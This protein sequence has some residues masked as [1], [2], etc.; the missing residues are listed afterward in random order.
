M[1]RGATFEEIVEAL[2]IERRSVRR[3]ASREAWKYTY[4]ATDSGHA[5]LFTLSFLPED[6][7]LAV[8]RIRAAK[9]LTIP[10]PAALAGHAIGS[11]L[12]GNK[13]EQAEKE[14]IKREAQLAAFNQLTQ[15]KQAIAYARR[16]VLKAGEAYLVASG[17][18]NKKRGIQ[19]FCQ[20]YNSGSIRIADHIHS[21]VDKVSLS[22]FNRW[23]A[24]LTDKGVIGLAPGYYNPKKGTSGL[25][26]EQQEFITAMLAGHPHAT[27]AGLE[28]AMEATF[29]TIPHV[30][31]IRRFTKRWKEKNRNLLLYL[32]NQ[33]AWRNKCQFALGDASEQVERL[34]QVW[35]FD[36]TPADVMLVDGRHSLI[37]VIDVF[38]RRFKLL[39]SKTSRSTAVAALIRRAILDWG[40]PEIAKTDNGA[41]YVSHH[42]VQVFESLGIEQKLCPPFTPE[43]KPH[44]E[45]AFKTFSHSFL[46]FEPG[47]IGH[48]VA[49]RK[50]IESRRS[51]A[52]RIM[53]RENIVEL[54]MTA[55]ELQIRCDRWCAA[56]YHQRRHGGLANKT[57]MEIVSLWQATIRMVSNPRALDILLAEAPGGGSRLVTKN[58][59]KVDNITYISDGLPEVGTSVRVKKDETDLGTI[60]LFAEDG[61]FI[62]NAQDPLRTGI[63]QAEV[64]S[65]VN[66][67]SKKL[68][69]EGA[70]ELKSLARKQAVAEINERILEHGEAKIANIVNLPRRTEEYTTPALDEA[71]LAVKALDISNRELEEI[72]EIISD[73]DFTVRDLTIAVAELETDVAKRKSSGII[74]IF[75]SDSDQYQWIRDRE[76]KTP[77]LTPPEVQF[78]DK[79]YQ[80]AT[81]SFYL[82]N[83]GDLRTGLGIRKEQEE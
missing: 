6:V 45:R 8:A 57:P 5:K 4:S 81:G 52:E 68:M 48:S 80:S 60:H 83:E 73:Q 20:L 75:T 1:A 67:R 64:A 22:T 66:A 58:G 34:N 27:I 16:D 56:I 46:E 72:D 33:D 71:A 41:D 42:I 47:Y 32:T 76:R 55:E 28:L 43:A 37:G 77:G 31:S 19:H 25:S 7:R 14:R 44:I 35:E 17:N 40:V 24:A 62:C 18:N 51:F 36:S 26:M 11:Q 65:T 10:S 49:D 39:V 69:R 50:D 29:A 53:G 54:K 23:Q 13:A 61:T 38:S 70:K 12:A 82:R 3:R 79:Y 15:E 78:L 59:I 63:D 30:S 9:S 21:H 2:G 74:H